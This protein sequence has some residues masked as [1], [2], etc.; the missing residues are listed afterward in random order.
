MDD[1]RIIRHWGKIK[2]VRANANAIHELHSEHNGVGSYLAGWPGEDIVGLWDDLKQ[3][4]SQL[5]GNSGP[6]FLRMAG[7][8]TFI[9]TNHVVRALNHWQVYTGEPRSKTARQKIQNVFNHWVE[10]SGQPLSHLSMILA[11][12]VE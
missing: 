6:Y 9:L 3:R 8:D 4:F 5:G 11:C 7:K 10:E 12:S 1:R 2:S